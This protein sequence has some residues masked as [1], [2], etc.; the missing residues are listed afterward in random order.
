MCLCR[1]LSV[2]AWDNLMV[3]NSIRPCCWFHPVKIHQYRRGHLHSSSKGT[4]FMRLTERRG[5]C[6]RGGGN[7]YLS[8]REEV[9]FMQLW[10]CD[11]RKW[12][13]KKVNKNSESQSKSTWNNAWHLFL[14]FFG[15]ALA[16]YRGLPSSVMWLFISFITAVFIC[17]ISAHP[18]VGKG[19]ERRR[20]ISTAKV[21]VSARS[22]FIKVSSW[23][24]LIALLLNILW[25]TS[26][27]SITFVQHNRTQL[28]EAALCF[29][30]WDKVVEKHWLVDDCIVLFHFCVYYWSQC[31][32]VVLPKL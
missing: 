28:A 15:H 7:L 17:L 13:N 3:G 29:G 19:Q 1:W 26:L 12:V 9:P 21:V 8:L 4:F 11:R 23:T 18:S 20:K 27:L 31:F 30:W 5:G 14:I 2:A 22:H 16:N 24:Y 6:G 10:H 32:V 25:N